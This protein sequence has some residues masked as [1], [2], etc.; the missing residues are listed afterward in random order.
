MNNTARTRQTLPHASKIGGFLWVFV[1]LLVCGE[2]RVF[3]TNTQITHQQVINHRPI[4]GL[5]WG[6]IGMILRCDDVTIIR[7]SRQY[8]WR[9]LWSV[10]CAVLMTFWW[11]YWRHIGQFWRLFGYFIGGLLSSID[12]LWGSTFASL[13]QLQDT[14]DLGMR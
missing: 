9:V 8:H 7:I 1:Y 13:D 5:G 14:H 10:Y 12:D 6:D 4:K 11:L 3:N 2:Y